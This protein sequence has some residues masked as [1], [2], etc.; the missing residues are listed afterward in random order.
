MAVALLAS[1]RAVRTVQWIKTV[2]VKPADVA[3]EE[4]A[5]IRDAVFEHRHAF[6]AHAEG[7]ALIFVGVDAAIF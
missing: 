2:M 4:C 5:Q 7:E 1:R 3:F 6:N